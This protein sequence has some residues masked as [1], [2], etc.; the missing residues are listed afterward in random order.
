MPGSSGPSL[1]ELLLAVHPELRVL[2]MSGYTDDVVSRKLSGSGA[3]FLQK[4]FT[5]DVLTRKVR[6]VLTLPAAVPP[7]MPPPAPGAAATPELG[8]PSARTSPDTPRARGALSGR[9]LVVDDIPEWLHVYARIL[10]SVGY[11]VDVEADA[12]LASE[13]AKAGYDVVITD[14][15]MPGLDGIELLR[16]IHQFDPD[17]PV[18]LITGQ[19]GLESAM[20]AV[21]LGAFKYLSKPVAAETLLTSVQ[22]ALRLHRLARLKGEALGLLDDLKIDI[23]HRSERGGPRRD[24]LEASAAADP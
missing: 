20:H 13:K 14:I 3:A 19:P 8:A 2:F 10:E 22:E 6:E 18:I 17:V 16:R 5:P 23:G 9:I 24:Q 11:H 7:G 4:P 21:D 12:A 1:A 15:A